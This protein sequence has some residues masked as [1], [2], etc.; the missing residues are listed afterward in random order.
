MWRVT[1]EQVTSKCITASKAISL[2]DLHRRRAETEGQIYTAALWPSDG[3][4]S[5]KAHAMP[6][7]IIE[8]I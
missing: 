2:A 6:K 7:N 1:A 8:R 4:V 3:T 5:A